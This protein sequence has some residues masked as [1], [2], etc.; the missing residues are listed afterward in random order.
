MLIIT[1][2]IYV[3]RYLEDIIYYDPIPSLNKAM[4]S[5]LTTN[6][7]VAGDKS[8]GDMNPVWNQH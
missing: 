2:T 7:D 3:C 4:N 8:R 1:I 5:L 6:Q